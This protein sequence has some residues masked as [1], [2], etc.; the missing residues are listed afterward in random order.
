MAR[1]YSSNA[2]AA[3]LT[4]TVTAGAVTLPVSTTT[5]WPTPPFTLILDRD[6]ASE[7]VV[8]VTALAGLNATATRGVD[9]TAATS[10]SAGATAVHGLSAR[11]L[12][13]PQVHIAAATNVHGLAVG[14]AVVGTNDTQVLDNKT[15][16]SASSVES[17]IDV[18]AQ[19]GQTSAIM[20]F[21]DSAGAVLG[22]VLGTGRI[23]AP[24]IDGTGSTTLTASPSTTRALVVKGASGQSVPI[25]E[26]QDSAAVVVESTSAAGAKILN[27]N[28][29]TTVI[30][31]LKGFTA[32]SGDY[33]QFRNSANTLI[34]G[35]SAAG[36]LFAQGVDA[37]A[38]AIGTIPLKVK[39]FAGQTANLTEWQNSAGTILSKIDSVGVPTFP[40]LVSTGSITQ[41][42]GRPVP[43]AVQTQRV[44][45]VVTAAGS[46]TVAFSWPDA[47]RFTQAP[48]CS[49]LNTGGTGSS[50][51]VVQLSAPATTTGGSVIV[52]HRDAGSTGTTTIVVD[53]IGIQ[54]L[55]GSAVG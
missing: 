5:G 4:A 18:K 24:G 54:M 37:F 42:A 44:T 46:A 34:G 8:E 50:S 1:N 53:V 30:A 32:Q 48:V 20:R 15:F 7:E 35:F 16:Q 39:G 51:F 17:S 36:R 21:L 33:L 23:S 38:D 27:S 2:A 14:S 13:E 6:T 12:R 40:S 19:T 55:P 41:N 26:V 9:G 22:S 45:V 47:A 25:V 10:H 3:T 28:L 29:A 11:D 49:V 52:N 43:Y 31:T